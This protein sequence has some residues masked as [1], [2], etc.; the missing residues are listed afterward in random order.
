[1]TG[2]V[3]PVPPNPT[4]YRFDAHAAAQD[5]RITIGPTSHQADLTED[6]PALKCHC[7]DQKGH[8]CPNRP[9]SL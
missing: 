1:M 3:I 6:L 2:R 5:C 4:S 7:P 9:I 8:A